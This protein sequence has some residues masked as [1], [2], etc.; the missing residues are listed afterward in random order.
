MKNDYALSELER[1]KSEY[2]QLEP[3]KLA[4]ELKVIVRYEPMGVYDG[5]CKGFFI[6][7]CRQKHI[8]VNADLLEELQRVILMHELAHAVLHSKSSGTAAFH[9]FAV[10]DKAGGKEYEANI[11]AADYLMKDEDVLAHLNDD[12]S[13]FGA[14]ARL[15]VPPEL[16]DFKF[17]LMK[18]RGYEF[19]EPPLMATGDFLRKV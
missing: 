3:A 1:I 16:M 11:F 14:A 2:G 17:R 10:F 13:F 15:G 19:I 18:R 4:E 6:T 12:I 8:T 7:A 9:D 5:C